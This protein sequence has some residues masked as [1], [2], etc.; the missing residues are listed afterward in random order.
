MHI[1]TNHHTARAFLH[2]NFR[3]FRTLHTFKIIAPKFPLHLELNASPSSM[4]PG[5]AY[6]TIVFPTLLASP[7]PP[8]IGFVRCP[9]MRTLA[10]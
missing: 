3:A 6:D 8:Q 5:L 1:F 2:R 7:G 9:T 10:A 4:S